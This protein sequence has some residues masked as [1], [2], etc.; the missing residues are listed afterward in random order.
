[1]HAG[2]DEGLAKALEAQ[3]SLTLEGLLGAASVSDTLA[4]PA[5]AALL[6]IAYERGRMSQVRAF[7][8]AR[9]PGEAPDTVLDMA[10]RTFHESH[11][12]L[13]AIWRSRVLQYDRAAAQS[14]K[15]PHN[16]PACR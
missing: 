5:A 8:G 2:N 11:E 16:S 1:M 6:Q 3:P 15:T 10:Q 13:A 14:R 12:R 7:L 9:L 4:Y